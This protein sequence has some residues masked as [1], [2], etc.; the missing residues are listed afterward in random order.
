MAEAKD[1][2]QSRPLAVCHV[3]SGDLWGGA[4]AQAAALIRG[5]AERAGV[6]AIVFNRGELCTRLEKASIA[7][8]VADEST[9]NAVKLVQRVHAILQHRRPD[10][11]HVHGFKENLI[12]GVAARLC[13]IPIVRTH[14]GRGM[15]G[16]SRRHTYIERLNARFLTDRLIAVSK[17]LA[18]FLRARRI[19]L[20]N[21]RVILNGI[22]SEVW[23]AAKAGVELPREDRAF[24]IGTVGRLVAVKNHKCMLEAFRLFRN[25]VS[26]GRLVLIGEGPLAAH[27]QSL[28]EKLGIA[29]EI[30]FTGFQRDV[31]EHL[32]RL[33]VF[34]L[35]SLH[36]GVPISLL[37]AMAMGIPV[38][39]TRVGGIPEVIVDDQNGLLVDSDDARALS[40][41]LRK[42]ATDRTLA[43]RLVDNARATVANEL[44]FERCLAN[45]IS[46]YSE[47]VAK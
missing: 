2:A 40:I 36:E 15:V 33:D 14:H 22:S 43:Q 4:E 23:K 31:A 34:V 37:E 1:K 26:M 30:E 21:L 42:I 12:A 41:A 18:E 16:V 20:R 32:R 24:T 3:I 35:S 17:D 29:S 39:C 8:D 46:L 10:L 5:L 25:E 6:S 27:L 11:I 7:V 38:V 28:A 13:G 45:T 47:L 44:S 9:F 19:S